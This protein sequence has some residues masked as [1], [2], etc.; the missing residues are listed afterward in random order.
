MAYLFGVLAHYCLDEAFHS[1]IDPWVEEKKAVHTRVETEFDRYLLELDGHI[2]AYT[3]NTVAHLHPTPG[4]LETIAWAYPPATSAQIRRC[5]SRMQLIN[6]FLAT[7]SKVKRGIS[8]KLVRLAGEAGT[9]VFM[10]EKADLSCAWTIKPLL[11]Q[12]RRA[13]RRFPIMAQMLYDHL[14]QGTPL[15]DEFA[16]KF[17]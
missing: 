1:I 15:G 17:G 8:R 10:E 3:Q 9:G 5:F 12:Y 11:A 7:P 2:P 16:E 4:E 13:S 6:S 14:I